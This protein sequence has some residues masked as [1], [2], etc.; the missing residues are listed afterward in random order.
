[1]LPLDIC[2]LVVEYIGFPDA[3]QL[4]LASKQW[5]QSVRR[6]WA[7][8]RSRLL[9]L[10]GAELDSVM[11][12]ARE[13]QQPCIGFIDPDY[14]AEFAEVTRRRRERIA[15]VP[16]FECRS[17]GWLERASTVVKSLWT[18]KPRHKCH[19]VGLDNAGKTTIV[20]FICE[21]QIPVIGFSVETVVYKSLDFICWDLG[22]QARVRALWRHYYRIAE[23][24]VFVVDASDISRL[25][26]VRSELQMLEDEEWLAGCPFLVF[27][28][29]QD[30][31]HA[32]PPAQIAKELGV[33][34]LQQR[35]WCVQ[36]SS[37]V[38]RFGIVEGLD[39]LDALLGQMPRKSVVE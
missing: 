3:L 25:D 27:A 33:E 23:A 7:L 13:R 31:A 36:G 6:S 14:L 32:L 26:E 15:V 20:N 35:P 16:P 22:G 21:P 38:Q 28:H 1:M 24:V 17:R 29:K 34:R 12:A 9:T 4:E 11:N 39:W 5:A 10:H 8:W 37:V 30:R 18:P 2:D 19:L